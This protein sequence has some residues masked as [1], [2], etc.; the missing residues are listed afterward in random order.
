MNGMLLFCWEESYLSL[1]YVALNSF[2]VEFRDDIMD[3]WLNDLRKFMM[4]NIGYDKFQDE[5][6]GKSINYNSKHKSSAY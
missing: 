2:M 4:I 3:T 1:P 6:V 5:I